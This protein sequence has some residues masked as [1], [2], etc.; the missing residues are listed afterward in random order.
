MW[1]WSDDSSTSSWSDDQEGPVAEG[2]FNPHMESE[3]SG[4]DKSPVDIAST[5]TWT[6]VVTLSVLVQFMRKEG[7]KLWRRQ[8]CYCSR[9]KM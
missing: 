3:L 5:S 8:L 2:H 9:E 1:E 4:D 7:S 6:H